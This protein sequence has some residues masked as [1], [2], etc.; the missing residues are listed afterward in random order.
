MDHDRIRIGISRCLLGDEVRYDAGHKRD[1][2]ILSVFGPRVEWVPVCPEV[3]IGMGTPREAIHLL[4][5]R[6]G[7]PSAGERVRLVAVQSGED[8]T[9][10]MKAWAAIRARELVQ[11]NLSGYI[12]KKDSPSCGMEGVAVR[13]GERTTRT[14]RGLFAEALID[15]LP[16]LPIEEEGRL[17]DAAIREN[18]IERVFAHHRTTGDL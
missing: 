17:Q 14:G 16:H 15:A 11:L 6:D 4:A 9:A 10:R 1:A 8:W 5:S 12:L 3:E 7:V 13:H 18:F 2:L